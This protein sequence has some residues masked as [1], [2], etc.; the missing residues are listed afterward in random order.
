MK[1]L[2]GESFQGCGYGAA[3]LDAVVDYLGTRL[4]ADVLY[5]NCSDGPATPGGSGRSVSSP[6][7]LAATHGKCGPSGS[8][9]SP[10]FAP[11]LH[12]Q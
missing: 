12:Y 9:V 7:Q 8:T 10:P 4:G 1:L 3:T 2:I 11:S 6:R 5:T